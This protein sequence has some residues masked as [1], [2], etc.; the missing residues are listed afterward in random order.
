LKTICNNFV[1]QV[2]QAVTKE[3]LRDI[4]GVTVGTDRYQGLIDAT[5]EKDFREKLL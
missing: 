4:M 1:L 3:M 2:P 5:S